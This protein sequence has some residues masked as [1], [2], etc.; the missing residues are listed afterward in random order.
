[1]RF[2]AIQAPDLIAYPVL[3]AAKDPMS[4]TSV[5]CVIAAIYSD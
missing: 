5:M 4:N 3:H 1:M 2:L